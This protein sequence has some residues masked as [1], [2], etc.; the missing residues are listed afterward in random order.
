MWAMDSDVHKIAV[1]RANAIG[2]FLFTLPALESLAAA[3]PDA[4]IVLL[5]APWHREF[6]TG[7]PGPVDRVLVAPA[8]PGIRRAGPGDPV[9]AGACAEFVEQA[10]AERF[11]LAVQLHGGGANSN[12]L[13]SAL[14]ARLTVGA[15]DFDAPALDRWVRYTTH[16]PEVFRCLE[17]VALAGAPAVTHVPR[18]G[19]IPADRAEAAALFGS[20]QQPR[21]ILHPGATDP[22]RRWPP[23][24]FAVIGDRLA[25][26]GFEVLITGTRDE[27]AVVDR[28]CRA[29]HAPAGAVVDALSLG[30]L[31]A[32]YADSALVVANDTGPL[33]VAVAVG[34]P[35]VGLY[36]VGNLINFAPVYRH[37]HRPLVS[38]TTRCPMCHADAVGYRCPHNVCFITDITVDSVLGA[39][40]D[41]LAA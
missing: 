15:R 25:E 10:R 24:R 27:A 20:P 18:L 38:W 21:A 23:E 11:D 41:L 22:R 17:V 12:P 37:R 2:D 30:G 39:V 33:H 36:W 7:R 34:R 29:M 31:A 9:P 13:V 8:L 4:E 6:L 14:G 5:G 16:Q 35:T 40:D 3:Y 19:L 26:R 28:V 1:L 32:L